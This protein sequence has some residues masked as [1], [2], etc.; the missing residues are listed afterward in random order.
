MAQKTKATEVILHK[1]CSMSSWFQPFTTHRAQSS[2]S[3]DPAKMSADPQHLQVIGSASSLPY[4][5]KTHHTEICQ[6]LALNNK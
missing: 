1:V 4:K 6:M 3:Q 2:Y 5:S